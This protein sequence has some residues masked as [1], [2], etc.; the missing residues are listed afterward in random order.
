VEADE[1]GGEGADG[2]L[3]GEVEVVAD[4]MEEGFGADEVAGLIEGVAV[5]FGFG[6]FDEG[7]AAAGGE[8]VGDGARSPAG[9]TMPISSTESARSSSR[10]SPMVGLRLSGVARVWCRMCRWP[11]AAAAMTALSFI[12]LVIVRAK[13][14][15]VADA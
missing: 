12:A 11:G 3:V 5:A 8:E 14:E 6:L 4:E 13:L 2:A 1:F 15:L 10:K 9:M 7:D